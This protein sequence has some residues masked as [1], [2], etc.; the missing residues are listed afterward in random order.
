MSLDPSAL[1]DLPATQR[2]ARALAMV[3]AIVC[4][5]W[6]DRFYS[7]N[8]RWGP[9]VEMASMRNG[10]GDDWF[11]LFGPFGAGIK[12]LAHESEVAGDAVLLQTARASI[13]VAFQSFLNEPAFSWNCMSFCYWRRPDDDGWIRVV[14]PD[15]SRAAME[16]GSSEFLALLHTPATAYVE[17]AE[18][19]YEVSLPVSSVEA[20]FG[21]APLTSVLVQSINPELSLAEVVA[22]AQEIGYPVSSDA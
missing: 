5:D 13:P 3:E 11:L 16:D 4:P 14:H 8:S 20:I 21:H 7:Y 10:S 2:R 17:F 22:D 9:N 15:A 19:Y 1:P 12:G 18:W 6:Q